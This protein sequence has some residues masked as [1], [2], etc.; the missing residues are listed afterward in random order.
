MDYVWNCL[1]SHT[2]SLDTRWLNRET[3]N[4][5][6]RFIFC[7]PYVL[8]LI[9]VHMTCIRVEIICWFRLNK[10]DSVLF[11]VLQPKCRGD[12]NYNYCCQYHWI[13]F[14]LPALLVVAQTNNPWQMIHNLALN[15]KT[16]LGHTG[17]VLVD[18]FT[19]K[20]TTITHWWRIWYISSTFPQL[21]R[22]SEASF[23]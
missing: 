2:E 23:W 16:A 3:T 9:D 10:D 19:N 5:Y 7:A 14:Y 11:F 20:S 17:K 21:E 13:R 12:V 4:T 6:N 22:C 15:M 18:L 8:Q 1:N